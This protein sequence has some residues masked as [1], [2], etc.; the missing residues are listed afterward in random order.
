MTETFFTFTFPYIGEIT[1]SASSAIS[2][3][4]ILASLLAS[5]IAIGVSL[6]SLKQNSKMIEESS[7]PYV[8]IYGNTTNFQFC[9]DLF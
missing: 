1:L 6:A 5:L 4:G 9:S 3:I 2:L 7:R 8:V